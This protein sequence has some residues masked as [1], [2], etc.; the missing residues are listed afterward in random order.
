MMTERFH[1]CS[2]GPDED[3]LRAA[4][5]HCGA[6]LQTRGCTTMG[7]AVHAKNNLDG[8]VRSVFG[9]DV[10][11]V[12][13]RDNR[14]DIKGITIQLLTEKIQLRRLQGPVLAAFVEPAKLDRIVACQGVTDIV[15]VPWAIEAHAAYVAA[16][17]ASR[18]I[19]RSSRFDGRDAGEA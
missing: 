1:T 7:L 12:L 4:F 2:I 15:F 10:V 8:T 18:E 11:R 3:A 14:L 5:L 13:D 6:L 19:F 9:E 17:P 16:H